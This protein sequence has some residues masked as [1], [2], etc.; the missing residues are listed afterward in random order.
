MKI[1]EYQ[2]KQLF[3]EAGVPVP[4]G[5]VAHSLDDVTQAF[6]QLGGALAVVK[7]QIHAGGRGKG[8]FK[9]QPEQRGVVLVKSAGEAHENAGRM[10]GNT[11]VT[12]Q[13]G[14]EGKQVNTL[15]VEEGLEIA[16]ELYL[17]IVIDRESSCPVLI[18]STEGG[19]EIEEVAEHSPEKIIREYFDVALGLLPYQARK[20]AFAL[21]MEGK[22]VRSAEKFLTKVCQFFIDNDCSMTEINP[23]IVT[24]DGELV[25][26]DAKVTFDDNALF[27]HKNLEPFRDLSEEEPAEVKA[28]DAGL[29]YVKLDG[30]IGCL[31]NGAGLA[32]STMDL[33]KLHGG[34]PA[35]FLD[36][37]GGATVDAVTEAFRIILADENVKAVLVNIFGGIMKCDVIVEA[38]LTA[39]DKVGF[40]VPLVVRLEGTNVEKAREMLAA[41][42]KDIIT[43]E[44][45]TDAAKKVVGTLQG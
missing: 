26:L 38:L 33:I 7:S 21:G 4:R 15:F 19:M 34:E 20:M 22:T 18:M 28:Q 14:E 36:V 39:Y 31:V 27:R 29:S 1:H 24:G 32:M 9:E 12:I 2:A 11:L 35:N 42:G 43:A 8:T 40:H 3:R 41:S 23:L 16:R 10:M 6:Q 45:L 13:T 5:I 17:G 37:G 30:N 25:A 44:N